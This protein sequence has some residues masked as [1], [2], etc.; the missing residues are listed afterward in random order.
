LNQ[1]ALFLD[2]DGVINVDTGYVHT[3]AEF[4]FINGI[5]NICRKAIFKDYLIIV[6]TNQ[7]GIGRGFYTLGDFNLLTQWMC[8]TF[9]ANNIFITKVYHSPFHPIYGLGEY[10][11]N[12][13]M[14]KPGP[15]MIKKAKVEYGLDLWNSVLIGDNYTD[16]QAGQNAGVRTNILFDKK[17]K[18]KLEFKD[19]YYI[20]KNLQEAEFL[21]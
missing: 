5:F 8:G 15:G 6:I 17:N 9:L 2:R 12:D 13:E 14:R 3:V 4:H 1:K 7:A 16:V 19:N 20:V 21:L 11:R 18:E 10:K